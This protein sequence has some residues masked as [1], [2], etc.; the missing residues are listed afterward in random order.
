MMK[1]SL[2]L[3]SIIACGV[4]LVWSILRRVAMHSTFELFFD[5]G[6]LSVCYG[7][8][9]LIAWVLLKLGDG[10]GY[11]KA[12][13]ILLMVCVT[14]TTASGLIGVAFNSIAETA[15][16]LAVASGMGTLLLIYGQ[17]KMKSEKMT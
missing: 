14:A 4:L 3:V 5:V 7:M 1:A 9:L 15:P 11:R 17:Q 12:A 10:S 2:K 6:M 8:G 13:G 16:D